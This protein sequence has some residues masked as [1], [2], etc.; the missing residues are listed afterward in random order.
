LMFA[1]THSPQTSEKTVTVRN[2]VTDL[3]FA[4]L[5]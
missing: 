4:A 1:T 3:V 5:A 2:Q